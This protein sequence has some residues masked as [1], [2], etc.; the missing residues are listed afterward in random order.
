MIAVLLKELDAEPAPVDAVAADQPVRYLH[1][2]DKI[3]LFA[4][5]FLTRIFPHQ[6]A[7]VCEEALAIS[8]AHGRCAFEDDL[9]KVPQLLS[10]DDDAF[11]RPEQMADERRFEPA[12]GGVEGDGPLNILRAEG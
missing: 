2:L 1:H 11:F 8:L 10:P 3:H 4:I 6:L 5:G 7:P 9:Q 12:V